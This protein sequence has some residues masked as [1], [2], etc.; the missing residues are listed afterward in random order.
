MQQMIY[1]H[2]DTFHVDELFAIALLAR[3]WFKS[4]VDSLSIVRTRTEKTLDAALKRSDFVIDVGRK[5]EPKSFNFDHHQKDL[6]ETWLDG[7]P[8]SSCGMIFHFL[9]SEEKLNL[10][11]EVV[12]KLEKLVK[13]IDLCDNGVKSWYDSLFF[14][15]FNQDVI[16]KN[17]QYVQFRKAL[18]A[19]ENYID[20][21]I[22]HAKREIIVNNAISSAV[23]E[24]FENGHPEVV[25]FDP[26]M[27]KARFKLINSSALWVANYYGDGDW[28]IKNIPSDADD[29]YSSKRNMPEEWCGLEGERAK[30]VS[31]FSLKFCHKN[32]FVAALDGTKDDIIEF[33]KKMLDLKPLEK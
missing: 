1:T 2:S 19:A 24:S 11:N 28:S 31:G 15:S 5:Y 18:I 8:L 9:K 32:G 25:I 30:E 7:S 4:P 17:Q 26:P 14:S 22:Y 13:N 29:I 6:K 12:E 27:D 23:K 16:D 21:L 3:F 10:E 20:N 33:V